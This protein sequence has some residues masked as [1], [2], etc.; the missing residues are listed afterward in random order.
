MAWGSDK[1]PLSFEFLPCDSR[2]FLVPCNFCS[3]EKERWRRMND[4]QCRWNISQLPRRKAGGNGDGYTGLLFPA[5]WTGFSQ[6]PCW[7]FYYS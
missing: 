6:V 5:T 1:K 3:R 2:F 4:P 7:Y